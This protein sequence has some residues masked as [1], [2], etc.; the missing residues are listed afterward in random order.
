MALSASQYEEFVLSLHYAVQKAADLTTNLRNL[1]FELNKK[2]MNEYGVEREFDIYWEYELD[3]A[4]KRAIIECKNYN[5]RIT[6]EKMDALVGKLSDIS[7]D[8]TPIFATKTGYQSGA[9]A[10]ARHHN[11]ELL[12]VR[13][14][15]ISDWTDENGDAL[16]SYVQIEMHLS[17]PSQI[18]HF[19]PQIDATWVNS[20]TEL[21][22]C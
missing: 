19:E 4:T 13:E 14:Q 15:D 1:K 12:I 9:R 7:E 10:A 16:I 21:V 11:V 6:V 5:S 18:H 8:I 2:I 3:G 20:N 22:M 17:I